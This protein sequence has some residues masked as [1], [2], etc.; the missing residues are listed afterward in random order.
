METKKRKPIKQAP[1]QKKI[2]PIK[3][4]NTNYIENVYF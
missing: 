1:Y 4:A 3:Q 2:K